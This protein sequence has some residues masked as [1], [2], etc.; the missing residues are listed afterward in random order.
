MRERRPG[1]SRSIATRVEGGMNL[2]RQLAA[3]ADAK[4]G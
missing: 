4:R 3:G 2:A 1:D